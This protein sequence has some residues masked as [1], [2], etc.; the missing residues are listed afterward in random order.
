[1]CVKQSQNPLTVLESKNHTKH[2]KAYQTC[3]SQQWNP[4][5]FQTKWSMAHLISSEKQTAKNI[6]ALMDGGGVVKDPD[7]N[8]AE[9]WNAR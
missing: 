8:W 9:S 5:L 2:I 1:M 4:S 6:T 7:D 3:I